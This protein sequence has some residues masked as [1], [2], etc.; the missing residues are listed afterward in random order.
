MKLV[1]SLH[2]VIQLTAILLAYYAGF[3]GAQRARS[4]H[5]GQRVP[6]QRQRHVLVGAAALVTLL[7]GFF[8]GLII[9]ALFM[10][11]GVEAEL[12]E[13]VA[14]IIFPLLLI[15]MA[16][17]Y[18]LYRHPERRTVFSAIHGLNNLVI[19]LLVLIQVYSGWHL[20][21]TQVLGG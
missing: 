21:R 2:P 18:Y 9:M 5:L 13:T 10:P 8:G 6:F 17:G 1:L 20:Y 3:L 14:L 12:H 16:T 15:G 4:L 7:G 19:L 11:A